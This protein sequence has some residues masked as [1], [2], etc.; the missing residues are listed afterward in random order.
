MRLRLGVFAIAVGI[1]CGVSSALFLWTLGLVTDLQDRHAWLLYF[2]P[3]AGVPLAS[4]YERFGPELSRGTTLILEQSHAEDPAPIPFRL[5]PMVLLATLW[6][7]AFGGSA[8]REGT[9]VQMGGALASVFF[10]S[11]LDPK[12]RR[13]LLL[14]GIAGGFGAVFG[15]PLAGI[16]FALELGKKLEVGKCRKINALIACSAAAFVGDV[17]CRTLGASHT[18]YV[19]VSC[20]KFSL[21]LLALIGVFG[22][23]SGGVAMLFLWATEFLKTRLFPKQKLL[24]PVIGGMIIVGLAQLFGR[25]YLGLSLP[26]LASSFTGQVGLF[27]WLEKLL[28]TAVTIGSDF[29]GG[30]VTPLFVIGATLGAAFAQLTHQSV[31][32]FAAIGLVAVFSGAA[33][34]PIACVVLC[35]ELFGP[36]M[37]ALAALACWIA[38]SLSGRRSLYFVS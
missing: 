5:A 3:L 4:C 18:T 2:L 9:A 26:L 10:S 36:Q 8:G 15:T 30:E 13:V 11:Q 6:T 17:V 33:K 35:G 27:A 28:F 29:K 20:P 1:L 22:G 34:T 7:H 21:L 16:A 24:R 23:L 12:E 37:G 14:S 31:G 32:V 38:A 25:E 19:A